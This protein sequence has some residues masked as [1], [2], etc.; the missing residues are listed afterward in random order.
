MSKQLRT[1]TAR[2]EHNHGYSVATIK[3]KTAQEALSKALRMDRDEYEFEDMYS[4]ELDVFD[5]IR[6]VADD[7]ETILWTDPDQRLREHSYDMGRMLADVTAEI[8]SILM[9]STISICP[10]G[11]KALDK[12][13]RKVGKL[14]KAAKGEAANV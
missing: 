12:L 10:K 3:A 14:L 13:D 2:F 7:G 4:V 5:Y 1:Y 9:A 8:N 6:V 11:R